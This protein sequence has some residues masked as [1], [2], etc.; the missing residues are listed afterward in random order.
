MA[1]LILLLLLLDARLPFRPHVAYS[2][3]V[4]AGNGQ[5]LHAFLSRDDKWRLYTELDE[6]TPLLRETVLFKE[7]RYFRWHPGINPVSLVRAAARNLLTGRRT[8]G[9]STITMQT[10]RLLEPRPRTYTS[11]LIELARA[12][13]LELHY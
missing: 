13:Q 6:M 3:I 9:A 11:K 1:G 10:V 2:T 12:L 5:P 4:T 7:D 8:S